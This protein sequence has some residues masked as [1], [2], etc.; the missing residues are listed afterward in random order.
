[1]LRKHNFYETEVWPEWFDEFQQSP[2]RV[3][4]LHGIMEGS[5]TRRSRTTHSG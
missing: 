1:M 4:F 2:D 5:S 3:V